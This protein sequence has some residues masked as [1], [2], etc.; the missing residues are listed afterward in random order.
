MRTIQQ[1]AKRFELLAIQ[2]AA[3]SGWQPDLLS[4]TYTYQ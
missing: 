4:N 2:F 1:K 3:G